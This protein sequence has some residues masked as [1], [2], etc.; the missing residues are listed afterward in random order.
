M[1]TLIDLFG[2]N[3]LSGG[4]SGDKIYGLWGAD[5]LNGNGGN[6]TVYG[7]DGSDNVFGGSGADKLYG[8]AGNDSI[9]GDAG[10][11]TAWGG[12]GNDVIDGGDGRDLLYGGA[13]VNSFHGGE[14]NDTIIGNEGVDTAFY[15]QGFSSYI[16]TN[17]FSGVRVRDTDP[18]GGGNE[19]DDLL[20]RVETL[21]FGDGVVVQTDDFYDFQQIA[22]TTLLSDS[23][24]AGYLWNGSG[25]TATNFTIVENDDA[26]IEIG[27]KAK[28]RQGP[29][30]V[31]TGNTYVVPDG[32]QST[33]NGSQSDNLSRAA[34]NFDFS[35]NGDTDNNGVP[36]DLRVIIDI[37]VDRT[38]NISYRKYLDFQ[39]DSPVDDSAGD[40]GATVLD[41]SK[42]FIFSEIANLF[43]PGS[44]Y[45]PGNTGE[46]HIRL[47]VFDSQHLLA[48]VTIEVDI[49]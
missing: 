43:D 9:N 6:D 20:V 26:G 23:L 39:F 14:G 42:N 2:L 29:D 41:N 32:T 17:T 13:G 47:S 30:V 35:V 24:D 16:A 37:D 40:P 7:G 18:V 19:G 3:R 22:R 10:N 33:A 34:W 48:S 36:D 5:R 25:N 1:A 4:G 21:Q 45:S 28:I 31:P 44:P 46:H 8:D 27:L 49:V 11:D 15:D 38:S 12:A